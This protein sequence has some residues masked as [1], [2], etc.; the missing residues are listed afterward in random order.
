[1]LFH[2]CFTLQTPWVFFFF[3]FYYTIQRRAHRL[4]VKTK[5][6]W[7]KPTVGYYRHIQVGFLNVPCEV[8]IRDHPSYG[9]YER[10]DLP[11]SVGFE[12]TSWRWFLIPYVCLKIRLISMPRS[13]SYT[14]CDLA[15]F[16]W[17][18]M[19]HNR[20]LSSTGQT[21]LRRVLFITI[22]AV[23]DPKQRLSE[24]FSPF[25]GLTSR[26]I[27]YFNLRAFYFRDTCE[28]GRFTNIKHRKRVCLL[29]FKQNDISR[30]YNFLYRNREMK[31]AQ[32]KGDLHYVLCT[33]LFVSISI[34]VRSL[35]RLSFRK[36]ILY[37]IKMKLFSLRS[38]IQRGI[39]ATLLGN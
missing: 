4:V 30:W 28:F 14:K 5:K 3:F 22:A 12:L 13:Y 33:T 34:V 32:S 39:S 18:F 11:C 37:S 1:M 2:C 31:T 29:A 8:Q 15:S 19:R 16:R 26:T 38:I 21:T 35:R 24:V 20:L 10:Q 25:E 7:R 17:H 36:R 9:P 27:D 23:Y 6:F